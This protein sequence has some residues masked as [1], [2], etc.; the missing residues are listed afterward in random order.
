MSSQ[1]EIVLHWFARSPYAQKIAWA[2]NYKG[3]DYKV[4]NISMTEPRP[5]R[6]P[7]DGGYRKTPILQIGDH[8]YCDTKA[9]LAELE[10]RFP[11][12]SFYPPT[13]TG[14]GTEGLC[15]GLSQWT[16]TGIFQSIVS[17]FDFASFPPDFLKD[18]EEYWGRKVDVEK[19][20]EMRPYRLI[21]LKAHLE[22]AELILS[23]PGDDNWIL[24]T[25]KLSMADIHVAVGVWMVQNVVGKAMLEEFPGLAKHLQRVLT[26]VKFDRTATMPVIEPEQ[27]LEIV[28]TQR[29]TPSLGESSYDQFKS[30]QMVSVT[31]LDTGR[32]PVT[33][34]L[35]HMS[36]QE[37][38]LEHTDSEH[39]T[40]V[41]IHFPLVGFIVTPQDAKL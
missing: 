1:P 11:S 33:G 8:V 32:R 20:T 34:K 19:A 10:R 31:P 14:R 23:S 40:T 16:D 17:Q 37:V 2:L 36:G 41:Y 25:E 13:R 35:V 24:D 39:N 7:L 5:L 28:R 22:W 15:K 29:D 3:V 18:R 26:T 9:I 27:A 30:G 38:V 4:V 12:P 6:R 21:E